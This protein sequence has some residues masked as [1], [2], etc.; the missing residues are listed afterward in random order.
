MFEKRNMFGSESP[1]VDDT[2]YFIGESF[3]PS[4]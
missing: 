1:N 2:K 3:E 4:D